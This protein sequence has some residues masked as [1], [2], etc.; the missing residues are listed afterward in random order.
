MKVT[1]A[2]GIKGLAHDE[3]EVNV[4]LRGKPEA[5]ILAMAHGLP[6]EALQAIHDALGAE[7]RRRQKP[8]RAVP[9]R[10]KSD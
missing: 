6:R 2:V 8:S 1:N 5:V 4:V 9:R 10:T 3:L 7:V